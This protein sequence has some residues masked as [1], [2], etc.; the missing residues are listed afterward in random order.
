M[1][2]AKVAA[3]IA[4]AGQGRRFGAAKQFFLLK[5][6]PILEWSLAR[7][8]S[9]PGVDEIVLVLPAPDEGQRRKYVGLFPKVRA[10]VKGGGRR[11]DSVLCGFRA[12]DPESTGIVL[13]HDAA[14]P[15]ADEALI[16]RVIEGA[17]RIGAAVPAVPAEDTIKEVDGETVISTPDRSRL[18]RCQTPQG[19]AFSLLGQ[20]LERAERS[21]WAGNDEAGLV[22]RMG[23]KVIVVD[24]DVGNFKI[25]TRRDLKMAEALLED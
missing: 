15:L 20:A 8:E 24:G 22:E 18:R 23:R 1:S 9:H 11:Q 7:F 25:T 13:V 21:G 14:R 5:G 17:R 6:R 16:Q 10:V 4:A 12:L 19:F 2:G 3:I